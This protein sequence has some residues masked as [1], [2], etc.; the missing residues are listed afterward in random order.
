VRI[1][2]IAFQFVEFASRLAFG[3]SN[4]CTVQLILSEEGAAKELTPQFRRELSEKL[5]LVTLPRPKRGTTL[6]DGWRLNAVLRRFAPDVLHAQEAGAWAV[7]PMLF[8]WGR[9]TPLVLTVHDPIPHSGED[10]NIRS[11]DRWP[12]KFMRNRADRIIVLGEHSARQMVKA[13]PSK[14]RVIS[15]IAHGVL[16]DFDGPEPPPP[17][18]RFTFF[19]RV[20]AY[21]GLAVL[22]DACRLLANRGVSFK[23]NV[24]GRG[25]DLER[26]RAELESTD[27]FQIDDRYIP[28]DEVPKLLREAGV[29]VMPYL[30]ATQ[31][32]VVAHAFNAKRGVIASSVGAIPEI[33][34]HE[35]NGLLVP[36]GDA[37]ALAQAMERTI[38]EPGL[39]AK[40]SRGAAETAETVMS[41]PSIAQSTLS[42]YCEAAGRKA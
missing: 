25:N 9:R 42:V 35:R 1:S 29:I 40:L 23:V 13:E 12:Y 37:G 27:Y 33:V 8:F 3:L 32:G 28:A 11:R 4:F 19:G 38:V 21:K 2:L 14:A 24:A 20:E 22:I 16:G 10:A 6:L 36:A 17:V 30:D 18:G 26:H 41:W 34:E 31:S 5:T 15:Q 39:L 7:A